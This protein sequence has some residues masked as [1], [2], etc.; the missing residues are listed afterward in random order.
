[1]RSV[2]KWCLAPLLL[3]LLSCATFTF[4]NNKPCQVP[5]DFFGITPDRIP[6]N[7]ECF[8]LLD[9][10]NAHWI[11]TTIR[12]SSVER[13]EGKWN[14]EHWDAYVEK[15]E[16]AGKKVIFILAFDNG[17]IYEDNMEKRNITEKELPHYIKY[18]E[19]VVRQY[20]TRV[21]YEIWNEPNGFF[22]KGTKKDFYNLSV[23]ASEKIR[24]VENDAIILAG[25]TFRVSKGFTRGMFKAGAMEHAD[26]F[27]VHPYAANPKTTIKQHNKLQKILGEYDFNKPVWVTEVGYFTGPRPFFSKKRYPEYVV[28]TLS[29]FAARAGEVRNIVWFEL[30]DKYNPEEKKNHWFPLN[31]LGL[32]YP[33]KTFKPG[34]EA[35]KLTAGYLAGTEY[36]PELPIREGINNSIT[37]LYFSREDGS[38]V[39]ILW[40]N[41]AG[42]Q[43][44]RLVIHNALNILQ[45]NIHNGDKYFL[46]EEKILEIKKE[47][48]FITWERGEAPRLYK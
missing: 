31:H 42:N 12:W 17:W 46:P 18:V 27:S 6:L 13:E 2:K 30:M 1:M 3:C 9:D 11:R 41:R 25:S 32:M 35:Y 7:E 45:H 28:K 34:A 38:H 16:A 33:N 15:A 24:E 26:G 20:R 23:A 5:E 8:E 47:P 39:L 4:S 48:V 40:N 22:W 29:S 14:F 44:I 10:L 21:V 37:S 43:K 19:Q 36:N